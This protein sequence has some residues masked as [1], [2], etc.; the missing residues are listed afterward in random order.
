MSQLLEK[1]VIAY[2]FFIFGMMAGFGYLNGF[3]FMINSLFEYRDYQV[4]FFSALVALFFM[5]LIKIKQDSHDH[6]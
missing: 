4:F 5:G 1:V 2:A 6:T 3:D